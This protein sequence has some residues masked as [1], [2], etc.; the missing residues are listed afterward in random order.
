MTT[1]HPSHE[2]LQAEVAALQLRIA[3]LE[4]Q[5]AERQQGEYAAREQAHIY[6]QALDVVPDMVL[7]KGAKSRIA[8]ANRAFRD[9][10]GMTL[11]QMRDLIDAPFGEP[12]HTE[13]YIRDD[14]QV[15]TSGKTLDI[16][17]EPMTRH[18]GIV[19]TFHTIKSALTDPEGGNVIRTVGVSQDITAKHEVELALRESEEYYRRLFDE[20]PLGLVLSRLDGSLVEINAAYARILGRSIPETLRL[21]PQEIM[22][23]TFYEQETAQLYHLTLNS[24]YGPY[25]KTLL[26]KDGSLVPVR[27]SGQIIERRS[28]QFLLFSVEDITESKRNE[29]NE[30]RNAFQEE[31]IR[32]QEATLAELST[33]LI[34][35]ND[36]VV[37]MPLIG[38]L[39][40][41]RAQ[42]VIDTLL[43]G[44]AST[45]AHV[46]ILDVT[47]VSMVDTQVA[48][49]LIRAAQS[50]KL[51]GAQ[52]VLT[53][54]RPE[55]AQA[56]VG[57][58]VD[59]SSIVTRSTLQSGIAYA[60]R[61]N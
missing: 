11:E 6:A 52:A 51:L 38:A 37:V 47:G 8:F 57:L 3:G 46:V 5:L 29:E 56:L 27:L 55:V 4:Q 50:V 35:L 10:Y 18:D 49:G 14:E 34:P 40:S 60:I 42:Q 33:P 58:G 41:R 24:R 1:N 43:M 19:R 9:F 25:E 59:L 16:S 15:F 2:A 48:N 45:H 53:G 21:P 22:P 26:H 36:R 39:D 31:I 28:E 54:I 61:Q 23:E 44:I 12:N 32:V 17:A 20:M 7:I 13:Q 30:R